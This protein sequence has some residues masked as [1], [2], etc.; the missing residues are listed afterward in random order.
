MDQTTPMTLMESERTPL[1]EPTGPD[2]HQ[3]NADFLQGL[4]TTLCKEQYNIDRLKHI[5]DCLKELMTIYVKY[6]Q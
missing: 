3:E 4:K 2:A 6:N 1:T 5:R